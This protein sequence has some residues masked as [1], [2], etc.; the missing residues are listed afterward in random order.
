MREVTD[1]RSLRSIFPEHP[2]RWFWERVPI[3]LEWLF[4]SVIGFLLISGVITGHHDVWDFVRGGQLGV[5]L[6]AVVYFVHGH[7]HSGSHHR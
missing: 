2:G 4:Y 3:Y 7:H 5:L 1:A 6:A